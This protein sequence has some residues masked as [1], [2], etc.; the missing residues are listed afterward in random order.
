MIMPTLALA[1]PLAAVITRVLKESLREAMV[2]DYVLLARLKGMSQLRLVLQ[3][4]LAQ[5]RRA[6]RSR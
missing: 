2:Q 3:E 6:R 4:A 1:L 5:R